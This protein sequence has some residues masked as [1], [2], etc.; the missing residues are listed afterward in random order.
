MNWN[1]LSLNKFTSDNYNDL[2]YLHITST[3]LPSADQK[4]QI[5][6]HTSKWTNV[7]IYQHINNP[8]SEEV[9][10]SSRRM[11]NVRLR[12]VSQ[13]LFQALKNSGFT[14]ASFWKY[15]FS[16]SK[17]VSGKFIFQWFSM[18]VPDTRWKLPTGS[19]PE[20]DI[21]HSLEV[22]PPLLHCSGNEI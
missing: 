6:N 12:K 15:K 18:E 19:S 9:L 2:Q 3:E 21:C 14:V 16:D 5:N 4:C 20:F 1:R 13:W 7:Y 10:K 22:P 11:T 17:R 8:Y